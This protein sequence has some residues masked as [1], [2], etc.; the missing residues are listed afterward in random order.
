MFYQF[1]EGG[2]AA[3]RSAEEIAKT[4]CAVRAQIALAEAERE[5]LLRA[6]GQRDLGGVSCLLS[7]CESA[8]SLKSRLSLLY[9]LLDDLKEELAESLYATGEL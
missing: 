6:A 3:H 7:L 9:D 1:K 8:E 4:L 2:V 5:K